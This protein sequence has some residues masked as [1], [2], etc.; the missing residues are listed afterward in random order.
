M[1]AMAAIAIA[2]AIARLKDI[3]IN[4]RLCLPLLQGWFPLP[5]FFDGF[6]NDNNKFPD[7]LSKYAAGRT[8]LGF[9]IP[10]KVLFV[11]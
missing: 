5:S 4:S 1:V 6:P 3:A 7:S 8:S 10:R 2:V 9:G 11:F